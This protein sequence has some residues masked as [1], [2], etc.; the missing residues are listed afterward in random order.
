MEH[1]RQH[2]QF[3]STPPSVRHLLRTSLLRTRPIVKE[4]DCA[5]YSIRWR[6]GRGIGLRQL[7]SRS[8]LEGAGGPLENQ[9][10][11]CG[12]VVIARWDSRISASIVLPIDPPRPRFEKSSDGTFESN[13]FTPETTVS[14]LGPFCTAQQYSTTYLFTRRHAAASCLDGR[15]QVKRSEQQQSLNSASASTMPCNC[16]L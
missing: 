4:S 15:T 10:S 3:N 16:I 14:E 7:S 2:F 11:R 8:Q 13:S 5:R 9:V 6:V 12:E 1:R